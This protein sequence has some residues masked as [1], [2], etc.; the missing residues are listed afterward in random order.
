MRREHYMEGRSSLADNVSLLVQMDGDEI[1][2]QQ[3]QYHKIKTK[4]VE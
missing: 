1:G 2:A 4:P 3:K